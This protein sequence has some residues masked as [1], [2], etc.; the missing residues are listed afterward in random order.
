M[1]PKYFEI[2]PN[3]VHE[4]YEIINHL[5]KI[6]LCTKV[7]VSSA[8]ALLEKTDTLGVVKSKNYLGN[9]S[10]GLVFKKE[11]IIEVYGFFLNHYK[12]GLSDTTLV[13]LNL[14]N[15]TFGLNLEETRKVAIDYFKRIFKSIFPT[16]PM[17]FTFDAD[18]NVIPATKFES[19]HRKRKHFINNLEKEIDLLLPY[20]VGDLDFYNRGLFEKNSYLKEVFQFENALKTLIDLNNKFQIEQEDIFTPKSIAQIIFDNY[21]EDFY[22][23]QQLEFIEEQ[24][25][26][27]ANKT[28]SYIF[29]LL[30]FFKN[31]L[32][33][34]I[35]KETVF[36]K[37]MNQYFKANLKGILKTSD[38]SSKAN[39]RRLENIQKDWLQFLNK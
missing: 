23:L 5:C 24:L 7:E 33:K 10:E 15:D 18:R 11:L 34:K 28:Y 19:L 38:S 29:S 37:I 1:K 26:D 6:K 32:N 13:H 31:K 3:D 36:R 17:D 12:R 4:I 22:S 30:F 25:N 16:N 2:I 9:L 14:S 20:L 27:S 21:P 8:T 35:P 39:Q